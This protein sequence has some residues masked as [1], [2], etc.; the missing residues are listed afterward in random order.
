M[1]LLAMVA[2][3]CAHG[4]TTRAPDRSSAA[5]RLRVIETQRQAETARQADLDVQSAD[6]ASQLEITTSAMIELAG[7]IQGHERRLTALEAQTARLSVERTNALLRLNAERGE[8]AE[9]LAALLSLARRPPALALVQ[10]R[11]ALDTAR[12]AGLLQSMLPVLEQRTAAL[13]Q[14]LAAFAQ[15]NRQYLVEQARFRAELAA[16]KDNQLRLDALQ[17]ERR[18]QR[19]SLAG[20]QAASSARLDAISNEARSLQ[21]LLK[22]LDAQADLR[23]RL[24]A[25]PGPRLRPRRL[26]RVA[27]AA[28]APAATRDLGG[29]VAT[30]GETALASAPP[31]S[32]LAR[33]RLPV[34]G[35][36]VSRFGDAGEGGLA[37]KGVSIAARGG[38]Q[39]VAPAGGRILFAGAFRGYGQLLIIAHG[40][41]YH[42]LLAGFDHID[43]TAGAQVR[44]GEPVGVMGNGDATTLYFE[45]RRDG[46]SIDPL[47]WLARPAHG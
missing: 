47:V 27:A 8:V 40:E 5:E 24:E 20:A 36:L 32:D 44:A 46:Q 1:A 45:V 9:L 18:R 21:A 14:R 37:A 35:R 7:T 13:R 28:P 42:L 3:P 41:G 26:G 34:A 16:L 39:V 23:Q 4:S 29:S 10:P 12:T 17:R 30:G 6:A 33:G 38:A 15:L 25:L 22:V 2:A 11:S 31:P 19:L 43:A